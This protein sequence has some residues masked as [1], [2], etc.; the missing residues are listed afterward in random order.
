MATI[1]KTIKKAEKLTGTKI[2]KNSNN[3]HWVEYK[4]H[5][6]SFYPNGR[7]NLREN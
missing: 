1:N 7:I 4:N 5:T 6:I 2:Q 3:L